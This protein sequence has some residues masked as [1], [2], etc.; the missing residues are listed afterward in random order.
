MQQRLYYLFLLLS[1]PICVHAQNPTQLLSDGQTAMDEENYA[2][3]IQQLSQAQQLFKKGANWDQYALASKELGMAYYYDGQ[4]EK[5]ENSL[6]TSIDL[7]QKQLKDQPTENLSQLHKGL[8]TIYYFEDLYW[9]ALPVFEQV[10]TI[11]K[12]IDPKHPDLFRDYYNLGSVYGLSNDY[13]K[14]ILNLK[15]A[16]EIKGKEK[17]DIY[18]KINLDIAQQ[19]RKDGNLNKTDEYLDLLLQQENELPTNIIG[20]VFGEY[21]FLLQQQKD[22]R[23]ARKSLQKAYSLYV[24][25]SD[26]VSIDNQIKI[27]TAIGQVFEDE[28]NLDS[29]VV[30]Y[31]KAFILCEENY[32]NTHPQ[33]ILS[34]L[35]VIGGY[36]LLNETNKASQLVQELQK[37]GLNIFPAKSVNMYSLNL[38][39]GNYHK[40][41]EDFP[42]AQNY[43]QKALVALIRDYENE[44]PYTN[45][46]TAEFEKA[47]SLD[48]LTDALAVKAR[49]FYAAYQAGK[50][51]EKE[52]QAALN[53][54][55]VFDQAVD[56]FRKDAGSETNLIWSDLTLDAYENAIQ[57]CLALEQTKGD[58][59][60]KNEALYF[61]EKSKGLT[62]LEAFQRSKAT[63]IGGLP[64]VELDKI[65][66]FQESI[67]NLKQEVFALSKIRSAKKT[68]TQ[69]TREKAA[70]EELFEQKQAYEKFEQELAQK[71]PQYYNLR[72]QVQIHDLEAVRKVLDADQALLEYFVAD[73]GTYL[74]KITQSTFDIYPVEWTEAEIK[75]DV[76]NFRKSIYSFYLG[77]G[78]KSKEAQQAYAESYSKYAHKF[79]QKL[80]APAEPLPQRLVVVPAGALA[81]I[82]FETLIKEKPSDPL[83]Y[84]THDYML[85]SHSI[86]YAYSSSLLEEMQNQTHD[87]K[88]E[89]TLLAFAPQFGNKSKKVSSQRFA[90]SPLIFNTDEVDGIKNLLGTGDLFINEHALEQ[91]FKEKAGEYQ[92]IHFAT[93]GLANSRDPEHSFLAFTEIEDENPHNEFLY[94][95]ELYDTRL[96]ADLVV[97][98]A[99]QTAVGK[100]Y[101]G[102]GV[103]SLARGFAYAGAKSLFT[104][105]WSVNDQSTSV[106]AES[107]YKNLKKG[108]TKDEALR[109]AKVDYINRANDAPPFLWAPYILVGDTKMIEIKSDGL[110]AS[111]WLLYGL[112]GLSALG[113][114][115]L[116]LRVKRKKEW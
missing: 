103:V 42:T 63:K 111:S 97:L 25:D 108:L 100:S 90:L 44:D 86:S 57:I 19:Y 4:K 74:I 38:V 5:A 78:S 87:K 115:G 50:G 14:A 112:G 66:V 17:D 36:T 32:A 80:V 41:L 93:H 59:Q 28:K 58:G 21:G 33:Y 65:T 45:I 49:G 6:K 72:H 35:N 81:E 114:G 53:T 2:Q 101:R 43:Y 12:Q 7:A 15:K 24:K 94:V 99:C 23:K 40:A 64:A 98:S 11:H 55:K 61:A 54:I 83:S 16:L 46:S 69:K 85:Q 52:L 30:Y 62:L 106:I 13:N 68:D 48:N 10:I 39:L 27:V 56:A 34:Q 105:L 51:G 91:T 77:G 89:K 20:P 8:G 9:N 71:Y 113:L 60:Y 102:E 79:Y 92:I 47:L 67:A 107:F 95:R 31:E 70:K 3:A 22:Y 76:Y 1:I 109:L 37:N 29:A 116:A 84:K 104:T 88:P 110:S 18:Y 96:N 82:P 75:R 26:V 73:G